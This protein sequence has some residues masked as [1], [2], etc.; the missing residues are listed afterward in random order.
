MISRTTLLRAAALLG[1]ALIAAS[2]CTRPGDPV[3]AVPDRSVFDIGGNDIRPPTPP[4][5]NEKY[6]RILESVRMGEAIIDPAEVDAT[7]SKG[8]AKRTGPVP[9][10][11]KAVG[12]LAGPVRKVLESHSML[13]GYTIT[14]SEVEIDELAVGA[15]RLLTVLLLRFPD[16][17]QAR[18]AARQLDATDAAM[19]PDNVAVR[20]TDYPGAYGHWRPSAPTMAG[21]VAHDSFVITVLAEHTAPDQAVLT[22]LIRKAFDL[23]IPRLRAFAPTPPQRL[24]EL[25]LDEDGMLARL[26]PHGP[27]VWPVP[28]VIV[29]D[30]DDLAGWSTTITS[31]GVVFGPRATQ[32]MKNYDLDPAVERLATNGYNYLERYPD[33]VAARRGFGKEM[34][35]AQESSGRNVATPKGVPDAYCAKYDVETPAWPVQFHCHV[36]F[37]RYSATSVGR[38]LTE[39]QQRAAAQYLLL[40]NGV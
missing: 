35:K 29:P 26:L 18:L 4:A 20:F 36:L 39:A 32:L 37:E 22:G 8:V 30:T 17:E 33:A 15:V 13:A 40:V 16:A 19:S 11:L 7:L 12:V 23:Q 31:S 6:G 14:G 3:A 27:G 5:G 9:S 28:T 10:P 38:N 34:R 24:A 25:P 2:G 1:A 21:T